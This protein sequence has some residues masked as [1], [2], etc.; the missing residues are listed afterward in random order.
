MSNNNFESLMRDVSRAVQTDARRRQL[1][2]EIQSR[3]AA[4]DEQSRQS[5]RAHGGWRLSML[6]AA[7]CAAGI[8]FFMMRPSPLSFAVD[9]AG[10]G[11]GHAGAVGERLVASDA[12]PLSLRFSDGSQVT[13]PPRAQAHV[14]AL[15]AHGATV[16]L[17]EGTVDVSVVH[18]A[19]TR[20]SIRV[21]R[22][23][24]RVTG[25]KFS[26]GWDRRS[27]AL[28]VTMREGSVEVT[29]PGTEGPGARRGWT[30]AAR[31]R[32]DRRSSGRS[33]PQVVVEDVTTRSRG[34]TQ[35]PRFAVE[36]DRPPAFVAGVEAGPARGDGDR[37]TTAPSRDVDRRGSRARRAAVRR[38]A[39]RSP[40]HTEW[41]AMETRASFKEAFAA[42]M[43]EGDCSTPARQSSGPGR[44]V[45]WAT[46]RASRA[47]WSTRSTRTRRR[48]RFP[49]SAPAATY[50]LGRIAFDQRHEL[51][52]GRQASSRAT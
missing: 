21:G 26:A 18:R 9:G 27:D 2:P 47:I 42:A 31:E 49:E 13:L 34:A 4:L 50:G 45:G 52:R 6:G 38:R 14:D 40:R 7:A 43:R 30:A 29:G 19:H 37:K 36:A 20:W 51:R 17:E 39:A 5:Q 32:G 33:E 10:A 44:L 22:Y 1:L 3:L 8:A 46:W 25:T 11:A 28:T 24:I 16:A 35:M 12:A 15:D 23:D 48:R 41:R